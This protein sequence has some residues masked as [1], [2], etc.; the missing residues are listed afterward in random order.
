[1]ALSDIEPDKLPHHQELEVRSAL[2]LARG[3]VATAFRLADRRCRIRPLPQCHSHVLRADALFR[4]GDRVAAV[5]DL[6]TAL[7]IAP[8]DIA[9]NRRMLS[10]GD[11]QRRLGAARRLVE[12]ERDMRALYQ[13]VN[14]LRRNGQSAIARIDLHDDLIEGWVTWHGGEQLQVIVAGSDNR[15]F[16]LEVDPDHPLAR[17]PYVATN[18][19]LGTPASHGMR[20][21]SVNQGHETIARLQIAQPDKFVARRRASAADAA[22][23]V[24][25]IVPVYA[26]PAATEACLDSLLGQ[27]R[28]PHRVIVVDDAAPDPQIRQL[29]DR[30]AGCRN[31]QILRNDTNLGF[32]GAV[33]RTLRQ[34][35]SGDVILLNADTIVPDGFIERL[36]EAA[37]S[38]ADIGTLTPFSNNGEFTSFPVPFKSNELPDAAAIARLDRHAARVNSGQTVDLPSGIGFCLYIRRDCLDAV[39]GV[40]S[41]SY[42]RGYYEDVDFCLHARRSGFR[43][44]CATSVY[45]GHAGSRSFGQDKRTLVVRNLELIEQRFPTYRSDCAEFL[46][47]DPLKAARQ[48]IERAELS[49]RPAGPLMVSLA[50]EVAD[51]ARDRAERL[52]AAGA[53]AVLMLTIETGAGETVMK[54][55]DAA[56]GVPQSLDFVLPQ[57]GGPVEFVKCLRRAN[58]TRLELFDLGRLPSELL[59]SLLACRV[60]H[61]VVFAHAELGIEQPLPRRAIDTATRLLAIDR[62]AEAIAVSCGVPGNVTSLDQATAT[63]RSSNH[64]V[65]EHLGVVPIRQDA[66][67]HQ[68]LRE[69]IA[70]LRQHRPGLKITVVGTSIDDAGLINAGALTVTGAVAGD[71]LGV[72]LRHYRIDRMLLPLTRPLFGHPLVRSAKRSALPLAYLDWTDGRC[73]GATGDLPI[74]PS[75][76]VREVVKRL[77]SWLEE[78]APARQAA[79]I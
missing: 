64:A 25:V 76:P 12:C 66:R 72:L 21:V 5:A 50:D 20:T 29:L 53:E 37:H 19:A 15:E 54:L 1:V 23:P 73:N 22:A 74:E 35:S 31:L 14:F 27:L 45:V 65:G 51:V 59:S 78:G 33:N 68:F 41:E 36:R 13:A 9:A 43:N 11:N 60:P 69:V 79:Q 3:D 62:E 77:L 56:S 7:D 34:V 32:A 26:D 2:A 58:L 28:R 67:E 57:S 4:M 42:R 75:L 8:D 40:L 48:A 71:E 63:R 47:V 16:V 44:V 30:L 61:D 49:S 18:F 39:G 46:R 6:V 38:A 55:R 10:W 24:T 52:L 70:G 17:E